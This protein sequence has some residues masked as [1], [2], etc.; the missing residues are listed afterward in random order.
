M[1]SSEAMGSVVCLRHHAPH[2]DVLRGPA[3]VLCG[4][5]YTSEAVEGAGF[6]LLSYF[7]MFHRLGLTWSLF[8]TGIKH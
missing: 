6:E 5:E 2:D 8:M 4:P 7:S 1:P 3:L